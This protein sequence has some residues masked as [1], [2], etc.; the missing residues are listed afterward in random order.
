M[1]KKRSKFL[2]WNL[3]L[4]AVTLYSTTT[5]YFSLRNISCI[6]NLCTKIANIVVLVLYIYKERYR[7][8]NDLKRKKPYYNFLIENLWNISFLFSVLTLLI[9]YNVE[10]PCILIFSLA[11]VGGSFLLRIC[12]FIKYTNTIFLSSI[13]IVSL[14][15]LGF[16]NDEIQSVLTL[17]INL[18]S[19]IFGDIFI[20]E[21]FKEQISNSKKDESEI[22]TRI[23]YNLALVNL[24]LV[25]AFIVVKSTEWIKDCRFFKAIVESNI[26]KGGLYIGIIR[27]AILAFIYMIYY[28]I[29]SDYDR[30]KRIKDY[31]FN[32]FIENWDPIEKKNIQLNDKKSNTK[33][34]NHK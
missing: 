33:R 23:K 26:I 12:Q 11:L 8:K 9:I 29:F 27:Y 15:A 13:S 18:I 34:N 3:I 4:A 19:L 32:L 31:L 30:R 1:F 16:F 20:K 24:G 10:K 25:C 21:K 2:W 7:W 22:N 5:A 17:S 28:L 6:N 14:F